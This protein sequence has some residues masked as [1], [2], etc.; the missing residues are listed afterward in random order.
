[1]TAGQAEKWI[2]KRANMP[3]VWDRQSKNRARLVTI[4]DHASTAVEAFAR[5]FTDAGILD[6]G[7]IR[8]RLLAILAATKHRIV[9]G[10]HTG[11]AI[12]LTG[13]RKEF[14]DPWPSSTDQVGHFLTAVRLAYDSSFLNNPIFPLLLG[15]W[16]DDDI[17][18][19]L[20]IGHEKA[21]DP[22]DVNKP[23]IKT[24]VSVIRHFRAQYQA[25]SSQDIANFRSGN[26]EAIQV[27]NGIGNSMADL[28]LSYKGWLFGQYIA[29]GQFKT[30]EE[31][32]Q[33]VR[34]ELGE[35]M[36]NPNIALGE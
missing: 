28:C 8:G 11:V 30:K 20:M 34:T 24:L 32:A 15:G 1:M 21:P 22:P 23:S 18:L 26:L 19:R 9:P 25:V 14:E 12:G 10:L 6:D 17:P 4:R 2:A 7:T 29:A 36:N 3:H 13:F 5:M 27:G 35:K 31:I 33:W 16:G